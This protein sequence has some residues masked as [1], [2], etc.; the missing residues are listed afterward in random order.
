M[1]VVIRFQVSRDV[2]REHEGALAF[3]HPYARSN[4]RITILFDRLNRSLSAQSARP[5]RLLAHLMVHE[6]THVLQRVDRHS[7]TGIMK[8]HWDSGDYFEMAR[9]KFVLSL[10]DI[11]LVNK[12]L[13]ARALVADR[14]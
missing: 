3:T 11:D 12:G 2:L 1:V 13:D 10:I 9:K 7:E 8:A 6:I 5:A 14:R 4:A